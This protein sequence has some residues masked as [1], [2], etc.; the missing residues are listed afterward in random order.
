MVIAEVRWRISGSVGIPHAEPFDLWHN[1]AD[2]GNHT[3]TFLSKGTYR[4]PVLCW[5]RKQQFIIFTAS[6]SHAPIMFSYQGTIAS[7]KR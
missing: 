5:N 7:R 4:C 1:A 6:E 2:A 3:V